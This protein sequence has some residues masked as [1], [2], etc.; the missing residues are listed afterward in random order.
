MLNTFGH[1]PKHFTVKAVFTEILSQPTV[2][3]LS[4]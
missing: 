4:L 3:T 1:R 2:G